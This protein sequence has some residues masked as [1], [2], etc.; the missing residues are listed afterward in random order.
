M[1]MCITKWQMNSVPLKGGLQL[2][3]HTNVHVLY[4]YIDCKVYG[5]RVLPHN[6]HYNMQECATRVEV[7]DYKPW[8]HTT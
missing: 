7:Q 6:N 3:R 1:Y 2:C 4:I 8:L 5:L